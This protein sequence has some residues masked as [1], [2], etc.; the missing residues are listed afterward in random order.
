ELIEQSLHLEA[1]LQDAAAAKAESMQKAEAEAAKAAEAVAE[2]G[3]GLAIVSPKDRKEVDD[4]NKQLDAIQLPSE[5]IQKQAAG[6]LLNGGAGPGGGVPPVPGAP[7]ALPPGKF[8]G[9]L[10]AAG[11]AAPL[12]KAV[13]E[14]PK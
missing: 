7:A 2:Q 5:A 3:D 6:G 1:S 12:V 13:E 10:P 4:L 11:G 8:G 14:G 9:V